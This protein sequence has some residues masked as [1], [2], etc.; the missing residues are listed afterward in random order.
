VH[1]GLHQSMLDSEDQTTTEKAK[2]CSPVHDRL[3]QGKPD[4]NRSDQTDQ[5]EPD[6]MTRI[7]SM[8]TCLC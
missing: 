4:L 7:M 5:T 1:T 2:T 8:L 6:S 3:E